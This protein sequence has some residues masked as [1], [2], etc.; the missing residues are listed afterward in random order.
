MHHLVNARLA[1]ECHQLIARKFPPRR[2]GLV[3]DGRQMLRIQH[4]HD[5]R[6]PAARERSRAVPIHQHMADDAGLE[7]AGKL[8]R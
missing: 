7:A 5:I 3:S 4:R 1:V 8:D 6:P 2:I